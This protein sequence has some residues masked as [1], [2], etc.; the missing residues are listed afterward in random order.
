MVLKACPRVDKNVGYS[1]GPESVK[2]DYYGTVCPRSLELFHIVTYG[3]K[4]VENYWKYNMN[5]Y[6]L[7]STHCTEGLKLISAPISCRQI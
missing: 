2:E 6:R 7:R 5:V 4:V 1:R 3:I